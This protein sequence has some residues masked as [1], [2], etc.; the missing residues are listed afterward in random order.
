MM[1]LFWFV[2]IG[3]VCVL[4]VRAN[5]LTRSGAIAAY[6]VGLFTVLGVGSN[7]L[8]LF[9]LFFGSSIVWSRLK[10]A[11]R[12]EAIVEKSGARDA[13]QVIANGGVAAFCSFL[14]FVFP[15]FALVGL[16][17][18]VGS[19]AA[20][21]AD[22]WSSELGKFSKDKPVH[23]FTRKRL[24]Q[25]FRGLFQVL[26]WA[27][28]IAGSFIIAAGAVFLWWNLTGSSHMWLLLFTVIGFIA[29]LVDSALGASVQSLYQCPSC[30]L[31]TE[32]TFHC[33]KTIRVKGFSFVTNDVVNL[34]CTGAGALLSI[35]ALQ[36]FG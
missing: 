8:L 23:L 4:L 9:L 34:C 22:T 6:F 19:L 11:N 31:M 1:L 32:K 28:A 2:I 35:V 16:V 18:F 3:L 14:M 20:A 33:Q 7:G 12:D 36:F 10:D 21:T 26:G 25:V 15:T 29:H 17:G 30:G 13:A 24:M 27:A 5:K